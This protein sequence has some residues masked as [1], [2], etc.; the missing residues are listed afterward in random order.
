VR[1]DLSDMPLTHIKPKEL[2]VSV[3]KFKELGYI[4]DTYGNPLVD[5]ESD[6]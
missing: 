5:E 4:N 6:P 2:G 1:Y 3:S